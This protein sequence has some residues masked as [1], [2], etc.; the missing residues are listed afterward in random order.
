MLLKFYRADD[1]SVKVVVRKVL[2][3]A[4]GASEEE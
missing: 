4:L 1:E 3:A 2:C